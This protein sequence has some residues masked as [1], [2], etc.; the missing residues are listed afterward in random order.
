MKIEQKGKAVIIKDTENQF[1][2]FA[3]KVVRE[4]ENF[5]TQNLIIDLTRVAVTESD[6]QLLAPVALAHM[7][8]NQS[9]VI[10]ADVHFSD[11]DEEE[12]IVVPTLQEAH[13]LIEMDEIGR[14]LGF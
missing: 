1:Q 2:D 4:R 5:L 3:Q 12:L 6:L 10:V 7:E 8:S 11:L 14:D 13:D 9:F